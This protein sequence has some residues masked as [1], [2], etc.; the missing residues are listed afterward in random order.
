MIQFMIH[1][2][3]VCGLQCKLQHW[4]LCALLYIEWDNHVHAVRYPWKLNTQWISRSQKINGNT[5]VEETIWFT[6]NRFHKKAIA[7]VKTN[8]KISFIFVGLMEQGLGVTTSGKIHMNIFI[9]VHKSKCF[10]ISCVIW[11]VTDKQHFQLLFGFEMIVTDPISL[12]LIL[13]SDFMVLFRFK[14]KWK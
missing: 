14:L 4:F 13:H 10:L 2:K 7:S 11:C 1:W 3:C 8:M 6:L 5:W 12:H 9:D